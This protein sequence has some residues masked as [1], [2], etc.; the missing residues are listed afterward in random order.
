M[1]G[2]NKKKSIIALDRPV[3]IKGNDL[4][5]KLQDRMSII[6]DEIDRSNKTLETEYERVME[7]SLKSTQKKVL[8]KNISEMQ[9]QKVWLK[10]LFNI[11]ENDREYALNL[12]EATTLNV[13][14]TLL[15][16]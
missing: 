8:Q 15:D 6:N 16:E 14:P 4:K 7:G 1:F 10:K 2:K 5:V 9:T 12:T 3:I 11:I 13:I